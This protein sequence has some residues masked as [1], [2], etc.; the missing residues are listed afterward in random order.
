M[1]IGFSG[2]YEWFQVPFMG[3]VNA[4]LTREMR[5]TGLQMVW[6]A[7]QLAP[8]LTGRLRASIVAHWDADKHELILMADAPWSEF[9]EYGTVHFKAHPFL[10]PAMEEAAKIWGGHVG[11]GMAFYHTPHLKGHVAN[12]R[13]VRHFANQ[14]ANR[15]TSV[16][17]NRGAAGNANQYRRSRRGGYGS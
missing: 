16:G 6:R 2:S 5:K 9:Q 14:A 8:V 10:R 11:F 17:F 3:Y 4:N 7:K 12:P 1:S 13:T 15:A